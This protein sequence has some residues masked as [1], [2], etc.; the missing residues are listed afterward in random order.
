MATFGS[1]PISEHAEVPL[2]DEGQWEEIVQTWS[3]RKTPAPA[4][5]ESA[6][7][8]VS[9]GEERDAHIRN[10]QLAEIGEHDHSRS[11]RKDGYSKGF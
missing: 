9:V 1:K 8:V 7:Y 10:A 3:A 5:D 6:M 11:E 2:A 4:H